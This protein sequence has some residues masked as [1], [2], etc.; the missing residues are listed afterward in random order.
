MVLDVRVFHTKA[1]NHPFLLKPPNSKI[2]GILT[3]KGLIS[4]LSGRFSHAEVKIICKINLNNEHKF[5]KPSSLFCKVCF[6]RM[7]AFL[8]NP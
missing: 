8:F 7:R 4:C 1:S 6:I 2:M 3:E 5:A